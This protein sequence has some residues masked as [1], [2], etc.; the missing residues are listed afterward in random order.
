MSI[1]TSFSIK[2]LENLSQIKAHTIRIW[3]KR[4]ELFNPTRSDTNIRSYS[5]ED[6]LKLLN[7]SLLIKYGYKIST[8]SKKTDEE[9]KEIIE[10][11]TTEDQEYKSYYNSFKL[12]MLNFDKVLFEKTFKELSAIESFENIYVIIFYR[13]LS[14]VGLMWQKNTINPTQEH[15]IS[16]LIQQKLLLQIE[17]FDKNRTDSSKTFVLFLPLN[18]SH[19]IGLLFIQYLLLKNNKNTIFLGPSVSTD[20]LTFIQDK[21]KN[22]EYIT[23]ISINPKTEVFF[24][25]FDKILLQDTENK[26]H[27]FGHKTKLFKEIS[28]SNKIKFYT[29]PYEFIKEL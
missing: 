6:L 17:S 23:N 9:I 22:V 25:E 24:L 18:E 11:N 16:T 21:F 7:V 4:Y 27:V 3:E 8:I 13:L 14:E 1:Q 5:N 19:Q 20:N 12:S 28:E 15:F 29:S 26:L 2:D 10:E